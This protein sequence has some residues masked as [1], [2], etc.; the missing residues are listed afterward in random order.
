ME[1]I[2]GKPIAEKITESLKS[3]VALCEESVGLAAILV[4]DNDASKLYVSL[5][6][7]AAGDIG[8][9]F[10]DY[11]LPDSTPE[12][13]ILALID[14]LNRDETIDGILMQ[15]PLPSQYNRERII[16]AI[17]S[18]KDVDGLRNESLYVSP[19]PMALLALLVSIDLEI[20]GK[21]AVILA[22]S[23]GFG[24]CVERLLKKEGVEAQTMLFQNIEDNSTVL[25]TADIVITAL[26]KP[27][28]LTADMIR[29]DAILI[30][31]GI[32]RIGEAVVGDVDVKSVARKA[33]FITPVP[34]GVGPVTVACLMNNVY[35]SALKRGKCETI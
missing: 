12:A 18:T 21:R 3:S 4:G 9:V 23:R 34:G 2:Y 24:E 5:K 10:L 14:T 6:E 25:Q 17:D 15:L 26:G 1:Y 29:E 22:N 11:Y 8:F 13:D 7:R 32:E 33:A 16:S 30:D 28:F 19:F 31:G 35:T 20:T 27:N